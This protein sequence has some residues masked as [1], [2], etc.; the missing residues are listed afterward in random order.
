MLGPV[1]C[2]TVYTNMFRMADFTMLPSPVSHLKKDQS[3][4]YLM[5]LLYKLDFQALS[6]G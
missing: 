5:C 1:K 4:L 6:V 3:P 2:R